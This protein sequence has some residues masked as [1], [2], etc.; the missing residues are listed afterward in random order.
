MGRRQV[1]KERNDVATALLGLCQRGCGS[2]TGALRFAGIVEIISN[3]IRLTKLLKDQDLF[4]KVSTFFMNLQISCTPDD[5]VFVTKFR[6]I[7]EL[8]QWSLN[9]PAQNVLQI[10]INPTQSSLVGVFNLLSCERE[11]NLKTKRSSEKGEFISAME[12]SHGQKARP[13]TL[14]VRITT[15]TSESTAAASLMQNLN[16]A[17]LTFTVDVCNRDNDECRLSN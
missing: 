5:Q 7:D 15:R 4:L 1:K 9:S 8:M 10:V 17:C 2:V 3:F 13:S 14:E 6:L 16:T 12:C 11:K